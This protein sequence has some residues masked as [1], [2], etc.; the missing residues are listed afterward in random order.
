MLIFSLKIFEIKKEV[1][2]KRGLVLVALLCCA[3]SFGQCY[4]KTNL[5]GD[6][7]SQIQAINFPSKT[8]L[9]QFFETTAVI[10]ELLQQDSFCLNDSQES[11]LQ[12]YLGETFL[13]QRSSSGDLLDPYLA[14]LFSSTLYS[15]YQQQISQEEFDKIT[16]ALAGYYVCYRHI[17][18]N[19]NELYA[20]VKKLAVSSELLNEVMEQ[21][22]QV[23]T[24]YAMNGSA[25]GKRKLRAVKKD[26]L[27]GAYYAMPPDYRLHIDEK[28]EFGNNLASLIPKLMVQPEESAM[29]LTNAPLIFV[30]KKTTN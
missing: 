14:K 12:I 4:V 24:Q 15:D 2:S 17:T 13:N 6:I 19:W 18:M 20:D 22:A 8:E 1:T 3:L 9:E 29:T 25:A 28:Q 11:G 7:D 26:F 21:Y 16:D 27:T 5:P 23:R 30:I 10:Y